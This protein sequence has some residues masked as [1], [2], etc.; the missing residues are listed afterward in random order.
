MKKAEDKKVI[1]LDLDGVL[2]EYSGVFDPEF[3]PPIRKGAKEFVEKLSMDFELK[4]FTTRNRLLAVKW[5]IDNNLDNYIDDV[6]SVKE[7]GWLIIDDRCVNFDGNYHSL[8]RGII[9][10]KTWWK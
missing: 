1:L 5:L 7:P 3:I 4:L 8:Y 6:T 2:N 10:F 9:S